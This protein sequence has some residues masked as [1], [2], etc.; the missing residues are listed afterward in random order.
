M[1]GGGKDREECI[2]GD[3][4]EVEGEG[5]DMW[6]KKW[7]RETPHAILPLHTFADHS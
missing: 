7:E 4:R 1:L 5:G 3:G 6:D 2:E